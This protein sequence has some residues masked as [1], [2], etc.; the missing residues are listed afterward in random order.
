MSIDSAAVSEVVCV[1][2]FLADVDGNSQWNV[3]AS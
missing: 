3:H 2:V 1:T